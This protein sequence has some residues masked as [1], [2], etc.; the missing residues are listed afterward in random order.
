MRISIIDKYEINIMNN[1]KLMFFTFLTEL[2][3]DSKKPNIDNLKELNQTP[4]L[5]S[6]NNNENDKAKSTTSNLRRGK[7]I[8]IADEQ[9]SSSTKKD[10]TNNNDTEMLVMLKSQRDLLQSFQEE[11]QNLRAE[12]RSQAASEC[13]I[14]DQGTKVVTP[15]KKQI[16]SVR[17]AVPSRRLYPNLCPGTAP[18]KRKRVQPISTT[19]WTP[20]STRQ[21]ANS[22]ETFSRLQTYVDR[23]KHH[24]EDQFLSDDDNDDDEENELEDD[25]ERPAL[26]NKSLRVKGRPTLNMKQQ[27]LFEKVKLWQRKN[28]DAPVDKDGFTIPYMTPTIKKSLNEKSSAT[29]SYLKTPNVF[30]PK[31]LHKLQ[32]APKKKEVTKKRCLTSSDEGYCDT[33]EV[34]SDEC[35]AGPG[36]RRTLFD[37]SDEASTIYQ[38]EQKAPMVE[39]VSAICHGCNPSLLLDSTSFM[40]AIQSS[41]N[42]CDFHYE[43]IKTIKQ[44]YL[45]FNQQRQQQQQTTLTTQQQQHQSVYKLKFNQ[46]QPRQPVKHPHR[47][48]Q[49]PKPVLPVQ[50]SRKRIPSRGLLRK[51]KDWESMSVFSYRSEVSL[52]SHATEKTV[53]FFL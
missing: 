2:N 22:S 8:L 25:D 43:L 46:H 7:R 13:D 49:L 16:G 33:A 41:V 34:D 52:K 17:S 10:K 3:G 30:N 39:E 19:C 32:L 53:S 6:L 9:V 45:V 5:M 37:R 28:L 44:S 18:S 36:I 23:S 40:T 47:Q 24:Q 15:L 14:T 4:G 38:D 11:I 1:E 12:V 26:N 20:Q 50:V 27:S 21:R 35:V 51:E 48:H 29:S 42:T 31:H